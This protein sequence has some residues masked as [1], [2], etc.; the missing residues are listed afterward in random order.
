[1][2]PVIGRLLVRIQPR[3]QV[4]DVTPEDV[5]QLVKLVERPSDLAAHPVG[6]LRLTDAKRSG[7]IGATELPSAHHRA[8]FLSNPG[9]GAR[10]HG[11]LSHGFMLWPTPIA[12]QARPTEMALKSYAWA[13]PM[14]RGAHSLL[15]MTKPNRPTAAVSEEIRAQLARRRHTQGELAEALGISQPQVSARLHGRI[16]WSV[17]EVAVVARWLDVPM[18]A[19]IRDAA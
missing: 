9:R 14:R 11:C 7:K 1:M 3:E 4:P 17:D 16:A 19:L 13:L 15:D 18:S 2:R 5:G 6:N 10:H 12:C 8:Y